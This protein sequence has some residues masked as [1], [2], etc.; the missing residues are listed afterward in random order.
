MGSPAQERA[1]EA[2]ELQAL[3]DAELEKISG[4]GVRELLHYL[5]DQTALPHYA[6]VGEP[7]A[8]VVHDQI[9]AVHGF[10]PVKQT[11]VDVA[12]GEVEA[13]QARFDALRAAEKAGVEH[14]ADF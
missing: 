14:T 9:D 2:A 13:A 3:H 6:R 12:R 11:A 1:A 4:W 8:A 5:L 7:P 10:K